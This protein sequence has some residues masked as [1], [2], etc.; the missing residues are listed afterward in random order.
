MLV[1]Q[2]PDALRWVKVASR[3]IMSLISALTLM[4]NSLW[5]RSSSP[6]GITLLRAR[7]N[8]ATG[9]LA[10]QFIKSGKARW[11]IDRGSC[12]DEQRQPAIG[13][14]FNERLG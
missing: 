3:S 8:R 4:S 7:S 6:S 14:R 5:R 1:A 2:R 12:T 10:G 11:R 9:N 13:M